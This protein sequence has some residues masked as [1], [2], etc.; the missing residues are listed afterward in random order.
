MTQSDEHYQ[1]LLASVMD[2][3]E[4]AIISKNLSGI[5]TS[6]NKGAE[7]LFGYSPTEAI[8]QPVSMLVPLDRQNEE[9]EIL[10][11]TKKG[12]RISR[13]QTFRRAKNGELMEISLIVS[14]IVSSN[15]EITGATQVTRNIG[16]EQTGHEQLRQSEERYRVTLASVGDA[17]IATDRDGRITFMNAT[18]EQ[19]TGWKAP[20]AMGVSLTTVFNVVNEISRQ[21]VENPVTKVLREGGVV[22]LANHT[23]LIS[24]DGT[25][26]PID[27]SG[28]P[29]RARDKKLAGVVLV[30]R[31]VTERRAAEMTTLWLAAIVQNS[32]DAIISKNLS[33]TITSWN[34]GAQRIFGYSADEAIGQS[35]RILVPA[36][37]WP[38]E[39]E[40]LASLQRGERVYH[41]ETI[42]KT[43]DGRHIPVSLTI[44]P[45]KDHEGRVMGASKI[46]RD[47]SKRRQS[48][49]SVLEAKD[50]LQAHAASLEKQ[51]RERTVRLEKTI[52]ELE[53]FSYSLSHDM[54]APL[55]T[56][57]SFS[58]IVLNDCGEKIGPEGVNLLKKAISAAQRMDKLIMDLL[59]FTRLSREPITI[60]PVDVDKLVRNIAQE[61]SEF[62]PAN[63][64]IEII[65]QLLPVAGNEASLTQCVANLLE[66]AVKFVA[67]GSRPR[68]QV[69]SEKKGDRVRI[70]FEDNGI[71]ID[72][73]GKKRLFQMFQRINAGDYPGTGIG[74]AIVRKAAERMGGET[75]VESEVGKG[76]R[77]WLELPGKDKCKSKNAF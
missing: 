15:G 51:V 8:G 17:V 45:I 44:S 26:R 16:P 70:W 29:I 61:R 53:A 6:W 28:A 54:R 64:D 18:A 73:E 50:Q 25:E 52:G 11:R 20:E 47:I 32:D 10:E 72:E 12:E 56:I 49:R 67:P 40:I 62:Q 1:A 24:K 37:L 75:G 31:D 19:L 2:A 23:V 46:A 57:E 71:G 38:E 76:S 39:D 9:S 4:D 7:N 48:E 35:I 21:E 66:N 69:Y 30:F 34:Q 42:R 63:A 60:E 5:I 74:L 59:A 13:F 33:G 43:K 41:F 36:D 14:P 55:R 58:Q 77:F 65:S 3:C 68:V 22:G 27:D